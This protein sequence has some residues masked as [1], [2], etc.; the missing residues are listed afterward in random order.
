MFFYAAQSPRGFV[1]ETNIHVFPTKA[2]R[3]K[4]VD[5][6]RS[7]GDV[8]AASMGARSCTRKQADEWSKT[9]A[10]DMIHHDAHGKEIMVNGVCV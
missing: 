5:D 1:N 4:W 10:G 9:D 7:D 6:H 3:D 2:S 8:N